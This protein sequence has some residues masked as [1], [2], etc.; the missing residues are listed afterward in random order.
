MSEQDE[1]MR[2]AAEI[3]LKKWSG[4]LTDMRRDLRKLSD[5][6]KGTHT[7]GAA[8]AKK[9]S[10]A[11]SVLRKE[12]QRLDEHVKT[13]SLETMAA[14]GVGALSVAG[15]VAAVKDAVF[16]FADS[17]RQMK[18]LSRETGATVQQLREFEALSRRI[19]AAPGAMSKGI[20][21]FA[22]HMHDIRRRVPA[23]ID[24]LNYNLG[25]S[26][27]NGF[28]QGLSNLPIGE[29]IS[30]AIGKL[31]TIRDPIE[32]K[33]YLRTLGL[34]ENL[35]DVPVAELRQM[36]QEIRKSI[37]TLGPDAEKS[38][39]KFADAI[40][41]M[42]DSVEKL[43]LTVG[44]ELADAFSD[45]TDQIREFVTENHDGL[46]GVLKDV[47]GGIHTALQDARDLMQVYRELRSGEGGPTLNKFLWGKDQAPAQFQ[48]LWPDRDKMK[49]LGVPRW[50]PF[51]GGGDYSVPPVFSPMAYHPG[52]GSL[53]SGGGFTMLGAGTSSGSPED[54][55]AK[56][57]HIGVL[58]ALREFRYEM[59][60]D[61]GGGGGGGGTA[62]GLS[63]AAYH[64]SGGAGLPMGG[65]GGAHRLSSGSSRQFSIGDI[66]DALTGGGGASGV[67]QNGTIASSRARFAEELKDPN[68]RME[69]AAMLLSEGTPLPT[70]ESAMNRSLFANKSLMQMLHS[71]FYGPINRGQ[72]PGFM[73]QLQRDPKLMARM[74]AAINQALGGS[75]TIHGATDQ[76][77]F[78]D[79]NG[80]WPGGRTVIGGQVFNDWGGGPGGHA[81]AARW[82]EAFEMMARASRA[83]SGGGIWAA[84]GYTAEMYSPFGRHGSALRDHFGYRGHG[85][86]SLRHGKQSGLYPGR[87]EGGKVDIHV[88]FT[89]APKGTRTKVASSGFNEVKMSRGVTMKQSES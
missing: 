82:R 54:V 53:R 55:I 69:F 73:A 74:N 17:T 21:D 67:I 44:S 64:P 86:D 83:G 79:P 11:V 50:N 15:A 31:D 88:R 49:E 57:T 48:N 35:A 16:G 20:H 12:F 8:H 10:E 4:P 80:R 24:A 43:K 9:H 14:F 60:G 46:V 68:K 37:G 65:G 33:Q 75:D 71:G 6:V 66:H 61:A 51:S 34:P 32:K 30:R 85:G 26:A 41:R 89:N 56:G 40:D 72:L 38:A 42:N 19:G 22:Q 63:L 76:G 29:A 28:V 45:A 84:P 52:S 1:T 81:G 2:L 23:E 58:Q 3:V 78:S 77:M 36:M 62:R 47:S 5:D 27:L 25:Y 39:L 87:L 13:T 59:E 18:F 7:A 70:A